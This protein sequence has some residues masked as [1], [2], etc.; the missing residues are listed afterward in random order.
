MAEVAD[1]QNQARELES[2]RTP[3]AAG[4]DTSLLL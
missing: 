2:R 4:H 3:T 1:G